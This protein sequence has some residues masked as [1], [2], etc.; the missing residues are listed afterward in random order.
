MVSV[1]CQRK[2]KKYECEVDGKKYKVNEIYYLKSREIPKKFAVKKFNGDF[3]LV[4]FSKD[5]NIL[6]LSNPEEKQDYRVI[7]SI[8]KKEEKSPEKVYEELKD[9]YVELVTRPYLTKGMKFKIKGM[10][11]KNGTTYF[12]VC[13]EFIKYEEACFEVPYAFIGKHLGHLYDYE[14][15]ELKD[16]IL[17]ELYALKWNIEPDKED[18]LCSF[19]HKLYKGKE[20][21]ILNIPLPKKCRSDL[22]KKAINKLKPEQIMIYSEGISS[23][24]FCEEYKEL[25]RKFGDRAIDMVHHLDKENA[26]CDNILEDMS[27]CVRKTINESKRVWLGCGGIGIELTLALKYLHGDTSLGN[28]PLEQCDEYCL[29]YVYRIYKAIAEHPEW[30]EDKDL[31]KRIQS[32]V[33]EVNWSEEVYGIGW[34]KPIQVW[35]N[36]ENEY[37]LKDKEIKR[38]IFDIITEP[39]HIIEIIG[40]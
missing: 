30:I 20:N 11:E 18:E 38:K 36:I 15:S 14:E 21:N 8:R 12:K 5:E 28:K 29:K 17:S 37:G 40:D 35:R 1:F 3:G 4:Y 6:I 34:E 39:D 23:K 33:K 27:K 2:G 32:A 24:Q 16:Y 25:K 10:E 22:I 31:L 26:F 7:K 13:P 19:V 9:S